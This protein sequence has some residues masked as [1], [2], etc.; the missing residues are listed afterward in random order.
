MEK[1]I[2][3]AMGGQYHP[4]ARETADDAGPRAPV[5][6]GKELGDTAGYKVIVDLPNLLPVTEGEL[7]L[8]ESEL[9]DFIAELLKT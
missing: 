2:H 3:G 9:T 4:P 5:D 6:L 1:D 8:L 7:E